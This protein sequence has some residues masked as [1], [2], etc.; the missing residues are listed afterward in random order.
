MKAVH[1]GFTLIELMIVIAI[2]STLVAIAMPA[3]QNYSIRAK[4]S[5]CL[6]L[7][8]AAKIAVGEGMHVLAEFSADGTAYGNSGDTR[9]CASITIDDDGIITATTR[10]TSG[11]PLA[12]FELT[13]E[14][15][16]AAITWTCRETN[17]APTSQLP[18]K[19][20][21]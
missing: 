13:P 21:D 14:R 19:C 3:Y 20:R 18:A 6:N 10:G 12:I 4:N 1:R 7:A 5:E 15:N 8:T 9:Y 2:L 16:A 11:D 17:S